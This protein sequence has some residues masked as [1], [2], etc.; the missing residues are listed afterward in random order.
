M[1][2]LVGEG[3]RQMLATA[4]ES[5]VTDFLSQHKNKKVDAGQSRFV[6]N[7]YC[8]D[9]TIQTDTGDAAIKQPRGRAVNP[10]CRIMS[11]HRLSSKKMRL[12]ALEK[13]SVG[14]GVV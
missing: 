13:R 6:H 14:I 11:R 8:P 3:A 4:I 5:D 1:T 7:G 12:Y 9:R 2:D 10:I